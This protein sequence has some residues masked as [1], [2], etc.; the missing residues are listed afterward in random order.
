MLPSSSPLCILWWP[1]AGLTSLF[2]GSR[3][4]HLARSLHGSLC[5][6]GL[7]QE[8]PRQLNHLQGTGQTWSTGLAHKATLQNLKR[9]VVAAVRQLQCS[10]LAL[11]GTARQKQLAAGGNST[12]GRR[13]GACLQSTICVAGS[14]AEPLLMKVFQAQ[15]QPSPL[16]TACGA[17]LPCL[18][19]LQAVAWYALA[20]AV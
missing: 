3:L 7:L 17:G 5:L 20:L 16:H 4:L 6:Q 12:E 14:A 13:P 2:F 11:V 8:V 18:H 10:A 1:Q 15:Y 19:M 9:D